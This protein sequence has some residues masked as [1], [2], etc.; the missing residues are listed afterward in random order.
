MPWIW[1]EQGSPPYAA[2]L[3]EFSNHRLVPYQ[4]VNTVDGYI[5]KELVADGQG[6]AVMCVDG[7]RPLV[8]A[9]AAVIWKKGW[10]TLP[11][12]LA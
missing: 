9:G 6:V 7:A 8:A 10:L 5:V 3:H 11:L 2:V 4:A 1:V 12:S